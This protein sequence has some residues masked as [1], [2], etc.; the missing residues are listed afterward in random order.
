MTKY[1]RDV[2]LSFKIFKVS[3]K[4]FK[5]K[6]LE[7]LVALSEQQLVDCDSRDH[8]CNGGWI[9]TAFDYLISKGSISEEDYPYTGYEGSCQ[10]YGKTIA[11]NMTSHFEL[12]EGD[13]DTL[14]TVCGSKGPVSIAISVQ[15]SFQMYSG[16]VYYDPTCNAQALNHGVLAAGYGTDT[17]G[18]DYWLVKNSWGPGWGEDGYIRMA[19]NRGNNCGVATAATMAVV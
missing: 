10:Y 7:S 2:F 15:E 12:P 11:A 13:E 9:P 16:G 17:Q 5:L 6:N 1:F 4:L 14:K 19:R 3:F 18:G 8:G